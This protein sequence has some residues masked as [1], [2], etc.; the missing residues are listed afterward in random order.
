MKLVLIVGPQVVGKMTLDQNGKD[1]RLEGL[2][3]HQH[4]SLANLDR[5]VGAVARVGKDVSGRDTLWPRG[6]MKT[7]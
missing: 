4:P 7:W 1:H 3:G 6:R 5:T 2:T